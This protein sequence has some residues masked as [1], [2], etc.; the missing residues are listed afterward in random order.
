MIFT[1][2]YN[3]CVYTYNYIKIDIFG[4]LPNPPNLR[5]QRNVLYTNFYLNIKSNNFSTTLCPCINCEQLPTINYYHNCF[6]CEQNLTLFTRISEFIFI[7]CI[8]IDYYIILI[9]STCI[10]YIIVMYYIAY[11][12]T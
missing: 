4:L 11:Y 9:I 10:I 1:R 6:Y 3:M 7:L 2:L 8:I 12:I 5:R